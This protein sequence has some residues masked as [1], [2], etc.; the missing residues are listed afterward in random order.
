M[1]MEEHLARSE[2]THLVT[3]WSVSCDR[4]APVDWV[5]ADDAVVFAPGGARVS[6]RGNVM[7]LFR[8]EAYT[9]TPRGSEAPVTTDKPPVRATAATAEAS[10]LRHNLTTMLIEDVS[11]ERARGL[12][13]FLVVSG[14]GVSGSGRYEDRY[15]RVDGTWRIAERKTRLEYVAAGER[16]DGARAIAAADRAAEQAPA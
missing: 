13:Y 6:G 4:G 14:E 5:W 15:R 11:A 10:W 3:A 1:T 2:I 8:G 7:G 9:Y 12:I 16:W